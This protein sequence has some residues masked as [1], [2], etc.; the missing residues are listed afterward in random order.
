MRRLES[1]AGSGARG[2][3]S[4]TF[5]RAAAG[6]RPGSLGAPARSWLTIR[7]KSGRKAR[8][9]VDKNAAVERREARALFERRAR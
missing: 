6:L 2:E 5:T 9:A 1:G 8:P 7:E 3:V 4:Q